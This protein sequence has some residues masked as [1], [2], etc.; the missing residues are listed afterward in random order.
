M[1]GVGKVDG[2]VAL[3]SAVS[4]LQKMCRTYAWRRA[5]ATV[6]LCS[7]HRNIRGLTLAYPAPFDHMIFRFLSVSFAE[8]LKGYAPVVTMAMQGLAGLGYPSRPAGAAVVLISLCT[9]ISSVGQ[10][11]WSPTGMALLFS[12]MYFEATRLILTKKLLD[13]RNLQPLEALCYIAP[14]SFFFTAISAIVIELPRF[15]WKEIRDPPI[16][17]FWMCLLMS[18]VL[19][20]LTN[21]ASTL[22]IKRTNVV[23][24]KLL[25]ISRNAIIVVCGVVA[26][27]D[28]VTLI[29]VSNA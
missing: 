25:S 16:A 7:S 19:G 9:T 10:V 15:R 3:S 23:M 11:H 29:Q 20:F 22:V 26:F 2:R 17:P 6:P 13:G 28:K 5:C 8:I 27:Q 18:G 14:S 12:S 1:L 4:D 24:L 21:L